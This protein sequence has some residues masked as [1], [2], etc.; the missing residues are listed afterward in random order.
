MKHYQTYLVQEQMCAYIDGPLVI[1]FDFIVQSFCSNLEDNKWYCFNDQQVSRITQEDIK[2]TYGGSSSG[3]SG[4][5]FSSYSSSTNAYMLMY[6]QID[7]NR[8][9]GK[10]GI[11]YLQ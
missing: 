9:A 7:P 8:N 3:Y 2:K 10:S 1:S 5:Y 4:F 11:N 6:R